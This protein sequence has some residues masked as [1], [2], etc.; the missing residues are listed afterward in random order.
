MKIINKFTYSIKG[1]VP[2]NESTSKNHD[3]Q[4]GY[5]L[6]WVHDPFPSDTGIYVSSFFKKNKYFAA[7]IDQRLLTCDVIFVSN[8]KLMLSPKRAGRVLMNI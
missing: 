1:Y 7:E 8:V 3:S 2:L 6:R 5:I 4:C